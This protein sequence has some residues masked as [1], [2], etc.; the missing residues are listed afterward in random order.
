M[1]EFRNDLKSG[2]TID[3]ALVKHNLTLKEA[4]DRMLNDIAFSTAHH[5]EP[6][7]IERHGDKF[8]IRKSVEGVQTFF[9]VYTHHRD[10]VKVREMCKRYGC[11]QEN[12]NKYCRECGVERVKTRSKWERCYGE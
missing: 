10:A 8:A 2:M 6:Q 5:K 12:I 1:T 11:I 4:F 3:E 9:G 7:Y